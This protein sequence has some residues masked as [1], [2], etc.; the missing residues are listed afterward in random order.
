MS[1]YQRDNVT[2]LG[3]HGWRDGSITQLH[4]PAGAPGDPPVPTIMVE[5]SPQRPEES[6]LACYHRTLV[7]IGRRAG[8]LDLL[9]QQDRLVFGRTAVVVRFRFD[10]PVGRL[11]QTMV[12]VAPAGEPEP[13]VTIF[14]MTAT[15]ATA[16]QH[17][18]VFLEMLD[19]VQFDDPA[20]TRTSVGAS[21]VSGYVS[22][23][24]S[25]S[26]RPPPPGSGSVR[27]PPPGSGSVRPP[28]PG[29]GSV[30]PPPGSGSVRPPPLPTPSSIADPLPPLV[31]MP[32]T[33]K[34]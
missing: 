25:G 12:F 34:R 23:P 29:S 24:G 17:R 5:Q 22:V 27:P 19:T 13:V 11:D 28:S 4:P 21:G 10:S 2:F 31:P 32:G 18:P 20:Q 3:P 9:D 8:G 1:R 7:E 15:V 14:S 16:E 26:V 30:R 33:R 6:F